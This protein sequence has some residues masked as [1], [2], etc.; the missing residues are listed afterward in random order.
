VIYPRD[1]CTLHTREEQAVVTAQ[2]PPRSLRARPPPPTD[3]VDANKRR[4]TLSPWR[5]PRSVPR[6][7]CEH[8]AGR[9]CR[10]VAAPRPQHLRCPR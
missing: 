9:S 4:R 10:C 1:R 2:P 7:R 5:S 8:D 6:T 3:R